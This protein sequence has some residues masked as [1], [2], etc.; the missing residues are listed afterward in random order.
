MKTI[1][2]HNAMVRVCRKFCLMV[3]LMGGVCFADTFAGAENLHVDVTRPQSGHVCPVNAEVKAALEGSAVHR[4]MQKGANAG[5]ERCS[6][7]LAWWNTRHNPKP[8][9]VE[10]APAVRPAPVPGGRLLEPLAEELDAAPE[11]QHPRVAK[12]HQC[13]AGDDAQALR[14]GRDAGCRSCAERLHR[15]MSSVPLH[16][17]HSNSEVQAA[18][19]GSATHRALLHGASLGCPRCME[20]LGWWEDRQAARDAALRHH[21]CPREHDYHALQA[22]ARIGCPTCSARLRSDSVAGHRCPNNSEVKSAIRGS[23]VHRALIKGADSGCA[24]CRQNLEWWKKRN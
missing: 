2:L 4:E 24:R 22:G 1:Y 3:A 5:C 13:P 16:R 23:S 6:S 15:L 11:A 21:V 17:C 12:P 10:G 19:R 8:S 7:N 14:Y 18:I 20:N 9:R